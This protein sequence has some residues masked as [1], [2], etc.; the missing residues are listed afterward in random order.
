VE[1]NTAKKLVRQVPTRPQVDEWI[2]QA[3]QLPRIVTY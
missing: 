1:T 3:K 2:A